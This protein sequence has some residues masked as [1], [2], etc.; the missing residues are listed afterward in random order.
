MKLFFS[1]SSSEHFSF[2]NQKPIVIVFYIFTSRSHYQRFTKEWKKF[3]RQNDNTSRV[4][5]ECGKEAST[6]FSSSCSVKSSSWHWDNIFA[7]KLWTSSDKDWCRPR[8]CSG[9][10]VK[11]FFF[12]QK[13]LETLIQKVSCTIIRWNKKW[14]EKLWKN[15]LPQLA[16]FFLFFLFLFNCKS[17][18]LFRKNVS[19][20]K[21]LLFQIY[22]K[23]N[24]SGHLFT[25]LD[26]KSVV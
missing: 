20:I 25:V 14:N 3:S 17:L 1:L 24:S 11:C 9:K 6:F 15:I 21:K 5:I 8:K 10:K 7:I 2:Y 12:Q 19:W 4:E 18:F 22:D 23:K 13:R 16:L 26:R